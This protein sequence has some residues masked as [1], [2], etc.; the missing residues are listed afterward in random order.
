MINDPVIPQLCVVTA[1]AIEFKT[2][3]KLLRDTAPV[4]STG[5]PALRG[6]FGNIQVALLKS[7][8]GA[9]GFAEQLQHHLAANRYEAVVVIGL[10]GALEPS[11]KTGDLVIYDCCLDARGVKANLPE[12]SLNRNRENPRTRDEFASIPCDAKLGEQLFAAIRQAKLR[13][14]QGAGVLVKRVVT[15]AR[16][17]AALYQR[18]QAAAVDMETWLVLAAVAQASPVPC[19]ALRVVLDEAAS[20][21][22]DFNAGLDAA[23][24]LRLG[25]TLRALAAQPL[26]SGRLL[27]SLRPALR[28]LERAAAVTLTCL[29]SR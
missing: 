11:L 9:P 28:S 15:E 20:D 24:Q 18:T 26:A 19:A 23:G 17:K 7:E 25:P 21:L 3:A 5:L 2:V 16:Q 8:I 29:S 4:A 14:R 27:K 22:P 1:A 10:A 12:S 13:C 6:R